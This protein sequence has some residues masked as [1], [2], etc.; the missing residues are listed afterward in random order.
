M[1]HPIE[2]LLVD[3]GNTRIKSAEVSSGQIVS[4]KEWKEMDSLYRYYGSELPMIA[5]NTRSEILHRNNLINVNDQ[6]PL[7]I[8]LTYDTP[9]TLGADRIA[10]AV[11]A[12]HLFPAKNNLVIDLGTCITMDFISKERVFEGGVIAPGVKMRMKSMRYFTGSLPDISDTWESIPYQNL[13]TSTASCLLAGSYGSIL[14]EI[15]G[16]ERDLKDKFTS[17]NVILTGGDAHYFESKVKAHIFAG[18]KIVLEGMYQIWKHLENKNLLGG[19][20]K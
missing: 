17:I 15:D 1:T 10:A 18:S 13:G 14:R 9:E 12:N 19:I 11:G 2:V 16:V 4:N 5:C 7:P 20:V 3:V 8:Q 6:I